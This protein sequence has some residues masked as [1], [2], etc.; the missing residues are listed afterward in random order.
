MPI[1]VYQYGLLYPSDGGDLVLEQMRLAHR[2]RNLLVE[3]EH[4]RRAQ[5]RAAMAAHPDMQPL[6]EQIAALVAQ[7]D[8]AREVITR[9]RRMTRSRSETAAQRQ[10]VRN[11]G[12]QIREVRDQIKA[13]RKA[14]ASDTHVAEQIA[15]A[16]AEAKTRLKE[17]R[18]NCGVYWG[19]YLLQEADA[20]AARMNKTPPR[21]QRWTEEGRVSVQI[22]R[23]MTVEQ[24]F[25]SDPR[26]Q[27]RAVSTDAHDP[28]VR[29]GD[30]RRACRTVLRLRVQSEKARPIW[31]EWPM[32]YHRPIPP[33]SVIKVA[34]VSR[35]RLD[36]RRFGWLLHLTVEVPASAVRRAT[37]EGVCALNL[38]F[39][40]RPD[41]TIRVGYMVGDDGH[42]QEITL[43]TSVIGAIGKTDSLR[44][45]RDRE[46]DK[47]RAEFVAWKQ[48]L[49]E[50]HEARAAAA[51]QPADDKCRDAADD[52]TGF[53]L[54]TTWGNLCRYMAL[55]GT[56][57]PAWFW[58]KTVALD[59]W[60]SADRFRR[61]AFYWRDHRFHGDD[62]MYNRIDGHKTEHARTA[63]RYRDE[64]LE[65]WE[66]NGRR[67]ALRRRRETYRIIAAQMADR[68][69]ILVI[70]DVDLRDFQRSPRPEEERVEFAA[71]KHAQ[72]L[73]APSELRGV[74]MN[75]FG[76]ERVIKHAGAD[77]T[78][79]CHGCGTLNEWNRSESGRLHVCHHCKRQWDQDANF[80]R[81]LLAEHART[82]T[83]GT[84][85]LASEPKRPSRSARFRLA[86]AQQNQADSEAAT[87]A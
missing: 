44:S 45:I 31:A 24:L 16:E 22:Q 2:Y 26:V 82:A 13:I 8:E 42:E 79:V 66:S 35:R 5:I 7:R 72:R 43:P 49:V 37:A 58:E 86:K 23:G 70:D 32:I 34:T 81:N 39:C 50:A 15:T 55:D 36:C 56:L 78:R 68:Y 51:T 11:L 59:K 64:H 3:I 41:N 25:Q 54:P 1:R 14:V 83:N 85:D 61:L 40:Q 9:Q 33:G 60:R 28:L 12:S 73:S 71:V 75:A 76:A 17:A 19:T 18:A 74:L 46:L 21:F 30:R 29:R 57:P 6:E 48:G 87:E 10:A 77:R 63:W 47:F 80:C 4:K 62:E 20:D 27:V 69:R 67:K 65:R 84:N 38:G 53:L 52:A